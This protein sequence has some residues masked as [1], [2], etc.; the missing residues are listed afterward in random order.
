MLHTN[1]DTV[2]AHSDVR[3]HANQIELASPSHP[4]LIKALTGP[5]NNLQFNCVMFALDIECNAEYLQMAHRCPDE[6]HANTAFV[7]LVRTT[8]EAPMQKTNKKFS[9]LVQTAPIS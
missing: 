5:N 7:Q 2:T 8:R 3:K 1:L 4:Y 9:L 6:V